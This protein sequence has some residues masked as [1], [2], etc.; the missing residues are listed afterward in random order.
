M[1]RATSLGLCLTVVSALSLGFSGCAQ[2][3]TIKAIKAAKVTDTSIK[4][5]GVMPFKND[6]ISQSSQVDSSISNVEIK[7]KKYFNLIDRNNIGK[8]MEE[9]KLNDSG[10]VDLINNESSIGLAQIE[11]LVTGEVNVDDVSSVR[12]TEGR[13]DYSTCVQY[14]YTKKGKK[15]CNKYR[16]YNVSCKANTYKVKTKIKLIKIS[17]AS[18]TFA[19]TYSAS[20]KYKHCEDDNKV[21]PSKK[22]ANTELA[23]SIAQALI[24]DIAPSYVYFKVTLLDSED[25]DFNDKQEK[26]FE[27]ALDMIKL[28]RIKKAN[29]LLH[30]LNN[31]LG[32]RSYVVLYDLAITEEALGNVKTAYN[33]LKRSEEISLETKGVVEE[34]A[35]AMKRVK[36]NL[37]E[38]EKANRQ[39]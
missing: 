36:N 14:A 27:N 35:I 13:T 25:V 18:T 19:N 22:D 11:T 33:L 16:K 23:G 2:K 21:L 5:I 38:L 34:V 24:K 6:N 30:K 9:K 7:G 37:R 17:D 10:L 28:K 29:Q 8:I 12:F 26:L 32:S 31:T 3:T 4:N 15:Y 39:L 1:K 20:K